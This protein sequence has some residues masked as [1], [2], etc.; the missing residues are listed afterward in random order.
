M[1]VGPDS[2]MTDSV[3]G[4]I[5]G[6]QTYYDRRADVYDVSMGY[7]NPDVVRVLAPVIAALQ[8]EMRDRSALEIACGPGFW[9]QRVAESARS[10][11]A[12]DYNDSTLAMARAKSIDPARVTFVRADA[13]DL[14]SIEGKYNGAFACDWLAHV[15]MSRLQEFL[16]GLHARLEPDARVV[17]CD[18]TPGPASITNLRDADGNHLQERDL[19]DGSRHMVIKHFFSDSEFRDVLSRYTDDV[20]IQRFSEQRRALVSY[21]VKAV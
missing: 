16:D 13:Y 19:P 10:I 17:F 18:Q 15:P 5:A 2:D 4:L 7:D 6:M 21:T 12:T 20:S 8:D 14:S 3:Y 9:T 1:T 11:L